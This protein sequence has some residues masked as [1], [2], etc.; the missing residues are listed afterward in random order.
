M[1]T[2]VLRPCLHNC[3]RELIN[4]YSE[5][6]QTWSDVSTPLRSLKARL[7]R[8]MTNPQSTLPRLPI[9]LIECDWK[10]LNKEHRGVHI[11]RQTTGHKAGFAEFHAHSDQLYGLILSIHVPLLWLKHTNGIHERTS[12]LR[13]LN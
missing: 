13:T 9:S 6:T 4:E 2:P 7:K 11:L 1:A 12:N 8:F 10:V 3:P 5:I